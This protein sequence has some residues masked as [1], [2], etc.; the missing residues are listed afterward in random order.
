MKG[1]SP[2]R[3]RAKVCKVLLFYNIRVLGLLAFSGTFKLCI[4]ESWK[5]M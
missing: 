5:N 2:G 3:S 1:R 4:I